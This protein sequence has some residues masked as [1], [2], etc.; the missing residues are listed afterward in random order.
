MQPQQTIYYHDEL[1]EELSGITRPPKFIADDY[2][3][4]RK[5]PVWNLLAFIA[6]RII[7]TPAAWL[8]CKLKLHLRI[9]NREV[10]RP[11]RR[12][13]YFLYGNHTQAPGDGYL[14]TLI[15][16]P[17]KSYEIANS[18]NVAL[19]GLEQFML[20]IGAMPIPSGLG[21]Y[22]NFLGAIEKRI[23][24]HHCVAIYPEAHI[25][26]YYTEIRPFKSTS[27]RYPVK[28]RD[29]SFCFTTTYQE[30]R[31][32]RPPKA[33]VYVDGPFFPNEQLSPKEQEK[34]LRNRIYDTMQQRSR[35]S[36]C[37]YI[38]YVRKEE[39]A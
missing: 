28:L 5:N 11:Y 31:P 35:L 9:E 29:P 12:K 14:P 7:M 30:R 34:D 24:S 39:Q 27:F 10:L 23:V 32:G 2:R 36:T 18:D 25:W 16:F 4:I 21:G 38:R 20:M 15:T 3:Y 17:K 13:G 37:R 26:P 1:N 19:P 6:Y 33:T 22:K 8:Y